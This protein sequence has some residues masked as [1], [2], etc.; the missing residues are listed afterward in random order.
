MI[1]T[2]AK[3]IL[4]LAAD[5][6]ISANYSDPCITGIGKAGTEDPYEECAQ[7]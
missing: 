3:M 4:H 5:H 6:F 2:N 1:E 7:V